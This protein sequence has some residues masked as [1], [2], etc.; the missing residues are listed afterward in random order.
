[1]LDQYPIKPSIWL[2][3]IDDIFMIWNESEDKLMDVLTY[4]NAVKQAI[5]FTHDYSFKSVNFLFDDHPHQFCIAT[6]S[7]PFRFRG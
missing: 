6:R 1:M 7:S 2:R 3:Y 4:I 5:Q